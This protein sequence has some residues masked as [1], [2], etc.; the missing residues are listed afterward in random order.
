VADA[1]EGIVLRRH[2]DLAGRR[3]H[4]WLRRTLLG[5]VCLVGVLGLLNVFGQRPS[6]STI[7]GSGATLQIDAPAAVRGGLL[8][9]ARF[10]VTAR[11]DLKDATLV[12]SRGWLEGLTVNTIEPSPVNEASRDGRLSLELGH[13]PAGEKY[14]LY[15]QYQ[16]NPT[17]VGRRLQVTEIDDGERQVLTHERT[18]RIYP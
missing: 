1:P 13:I 8:F 4:P 16:V 12:L 17:A 10:T 18:M 6:G 5:V 3:W 15:V 7:A 9:Q 11:R 2:R 14:A